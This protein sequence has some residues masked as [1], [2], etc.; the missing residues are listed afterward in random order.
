MTRLLK[1]GLSWPSQRKSPSRRGYWALYGYLTA[2]SA[3]MLGWIW[4]LLWCV[5]ELV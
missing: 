4:F 2:I 3:A 5:W 1:V